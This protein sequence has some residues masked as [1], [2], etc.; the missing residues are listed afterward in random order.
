MCCLRRLQGTEVSISSYLFTRL[1]EVLPDDLRKNP[2]RGGCEYPEKGHGFTRAARPEID[3]K[4]VAGRGRH[5]PGQRQQHLD[6]MGHGRSPLRHISGGAP[7][8]KFWVNSSRA[9]A[10]AQAETTRPDRPSRK[11]RG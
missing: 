8:T 6:M 1:D 2:P 10:N 3:Q 5:E 4:Q 9:A 7:P 11:R